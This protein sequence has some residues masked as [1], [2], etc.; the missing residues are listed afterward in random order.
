MLYVLTECSN[1][2]YQSSTLGPKD[3]LHYG[4]LREQVKEKTRIAISAM[5]HKMYVY[6]VY[7]GF[8]GK[9]FF[10]ALKQTKIQTNI[11]II[12]L[13]FLDIQ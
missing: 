10:D 6:I 12:F 9:F 11:N 1:I 2:I 8:R 3:L 5:I 4:C 13:H 7:I